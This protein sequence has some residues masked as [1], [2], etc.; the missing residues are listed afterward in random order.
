MRT[1]LKIFSIIVFTFS[2]SSAF[3]DEF[4]CPTHSDYV[5]AIDQTLSR[6]ALSSELK[7]EYP[8]QSAATIESIIDF[9]GKNYTDLVKLARADIQAVHLV[10]PFQPKLDNDQL[11]AIWSYTGINYGMINRSLRNQNRSN[12]NTRILTEMLNCALTQLSDYNGAVSRYVNLT[13]APSLFLEK[14]SPGKTV[15]YNAFTSS[16]SCI[17]E[18]MGKQFLIHSLHGKDITDYSAT[19]NG[20]CE[21][22]FRKGTCFRIDRNFS[23]NERVDG[24]RVEMTEVKCPHDRVM[25]F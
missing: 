24:I 7:S 13:N 8:D 4:A 14:H 12:K 16:S 1:Y 22:L 17:S 10:K 20:E 5:K 25:N 3:S 15:R 9:Y 6:S 19:G 23:L 11:L 2:Y 21:V 18:K